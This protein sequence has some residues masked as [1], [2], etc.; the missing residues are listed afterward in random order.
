MIKQ[1]LTLCVMLSIAMGLQAAPVKKLQVTIDNQLATFTL[2]P[3]FKNGT[4]L[5]PLESFCKQ[6]ELKVEAADSGDMI[7]CGGEESELCVALNFDKSVFDI[8]GVPYAKPEDITEPFGFEIYKASENRLEI[9]RAEYLA[10]EFTL[11][12]LNDV[13]TR[14]QDFRGKKTLLYIWGSW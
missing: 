3:I 12:D 14:L 8:G 13:P 4:W 5:V 6:L 9:F 10:P 7:V 2:N 11:P 1:I